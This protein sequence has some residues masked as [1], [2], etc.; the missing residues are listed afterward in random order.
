MRN[1]I[2]YGLVLLVMTTSCSSIHTSVPFP[3]SVT[4]GLCKGKC[5]NYTITISKEGKLEF[6]GIENTKYI[7]KQDFKLSKKEFKKLK[8][9]YKKISFLKL[10]KVYDQRLYDFPTIVVKDQENTVAFKRNRS[11]PDELVMFVEL[12]DE[13]LRKNDLL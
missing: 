3:I 4:K 7:G 5:P 1:Q 11:V 6:N 2:I 13:I 10:E 8:T 12:L 9:E